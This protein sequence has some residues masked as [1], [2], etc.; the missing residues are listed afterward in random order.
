MAYRCEQAIIGGATD[1][2]RC[3]VSGSICAH[4]KMCMMQGRIVLTDG[5]MNYPGRD[6]T[7]PE[8]PEEPKK[9]EKA[10]AKEPEKKATRKT[11]AKTEGKPSAKK[12]RGKG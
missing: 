4:Q 2:I 6:G 1:A 3:K 5:A 7:K 8:P 10:T 9:A 11:A 12:A